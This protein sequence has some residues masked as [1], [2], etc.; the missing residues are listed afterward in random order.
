MLLKRNALFWGVASALAMGNAV[1]Q[2]AAS[3]AKEQVAL[4]EVVITA[5]KRAATVQEVSVSVSA[6][7]NEA[8][9]LAGISDVSGLENVVPG[10]RFGQ[11]GGEARIAIRGTRT[12]NVGSEAEQVVGIFEDGVYVPTT[13]QAMGTYVDLERVEV[14]RGPQG[15]L[16]GRNTFGGTI[17]VI[18][19]RPDFESFSGYVHAL[20]GS[21]DRK[22]FEAAMNIPMSD[23]LAARIVLMDD[24]H[25]GY[26]ENTWISGPEDDLND[27]DQSYYRVAVRWAPTDALEVNLK[28]GESEKKSTGSAIWGYQQIGAYVNGAYMPGHQWAP[29]NA[30]NSF[31]EGPWK[32]ARDMKSNADT[33]NTF[34]T[35]RVDYDFGP[36]GLMVVGNQTEFSG[37]QNYD[38]DYSDGGDTH[39]SGFTGWVSDQDTWSIEAQLTSQHDGPLEWLVGYYFFEQ[40]AGWNWTERVNDAVAVP[41]WDRQG[42]YVSDSTGIFAN[43]TF[44]LTDNLR[45]LGGIRYAEDTKQQRDPLDWSVWPPVPVVGGGDQGEWTKVLW[46]AGIE[47]DLSDDELLFFTASTGYRAGGINFVQAGVP[48]N[49]DPEEVTA[50][51]LGYKSSWM[52]DALIFNASAYLN[53][54]RDMHAQSFTVINNSATEYTENGG[55]MDAMGLELE[56]TWQA[57]QSLKLIGSLALMKAEFGEYNVSRV[58]GLGDLGGRQDLNDP[59]RPLLSLEGW[60]PALAPEVSASLQVIYDIDLPGGSVLR[61]YFQTSYV[62]DHYSSDF[63]LKGADQSAYTKSDA[64]LIWTS[65]SEAFEVQAYVINI[66][67]EAVLNRTVVFNPSARPEIASLQSNWGNP[68]TYGVSVTYNY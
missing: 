67:D 26:I 25:D 15:T 62:G 18:T 54:Y 66:E 63:N 22:R 42:D 57:T 4:E 44:A 49:Y 50:F 12:N 17:N 19:R 16:Y 59:N 28:H 27:A 35:L 37:S 43:A 41:Y 34:S 55:E 52:D 61:P 10:M 38:P 51:E 14:L 33:T 1:A 60:A 24:K 31:D 39:N 45:V 68:R 58:D 46:K 53:Q 21:Y 48:L 64:R 9:S 13:T 5:T 32:V 6:L 30:S 20:A 23:T 65:A 7:D 40:S 2:E 36:V 56:T 47:H 11:S 8:L 3:S 29:A